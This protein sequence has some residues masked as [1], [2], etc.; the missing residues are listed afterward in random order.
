MTLTHPITLDTCGEVLVK[1]QYFDI[2]RD[3]F[4]EDRRYFA[5]WNESET[6]DLIL[7]FQS[8]E[9]FSE[10]SKSKT[11]LE[12]N[13]HAD[14]FL[15]IVWTLTDP[16]NPLGFPI[17]F[18]LQD[19]LQHKAITQLLDQSQLWVHCL[20]S[21]DE[22]LVHVYSELLSIS[23]EDQ[24]DGKR[25]LLSRGEQND[26]AVEEGSQ[27][28]FNTIEIT[29]DAGYTDDLLTASGIGYSIDLSSLVNK[30][31]EE[32]ARE[33]IMSGIMQALYIVKRHPRSE[34]RESSFFVWAAEADELT[35]R[36]EGARML[37]IYITPPLEHIFEIIHISNDEENPFS[38]V[39]LSF[40]E[41]LRTE[42]ESPLHRGAYPILTYKQGEIALVQL[43]G[44]LQ[45]RLAHLYQTERGNNNPYS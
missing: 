44:Q 12:F 3:V 28:N 43:D 25:L 37:T 4:E 40:T 23:E 14:Q 16:Q 34:A 1:D 24:Q 42:F 7:A 2:Y 17:K 27:T 29:M 19:N 38:R 10:S 21:E 5:R 31:G 30:H 26:M 39:F 11:T 32:E 45:Q 36:G 20:A 9:D 8:I 18:N 13:R 6:L 41:F 33:R 15:L 22:H 35:Q